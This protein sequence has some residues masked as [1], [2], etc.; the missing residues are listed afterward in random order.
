MDNQKWKLANQDKSTVT[1]LEVKLES[2]VRRTRSIGTMGVLTLA[3]L[4]GLGYAAR[5]D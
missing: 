1:R 3:L 2:D 5:G 4:E